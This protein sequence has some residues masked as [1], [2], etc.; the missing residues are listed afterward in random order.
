MDAI[1]SKLF[2]SQQMTVLM[3]PYMLLCLHSHTFAHT[4]GI[5]LNSNTLR[6]L[7][8]AANRWRFWKWHGSSIRWYFHMYYSITYKV[9]NNGGVDFKFKTRM[10]R[11]SRSLCRWSSRTAI[12]FA[13]VFKCS[14]DVNK[15]R[16]N[17]SKRIFETYSR[18]NFIFASIFEFFEWKYTGDVDSTVGYNIVI[19]HHKQTYF[20]HLPLALQVWMWLTSQIVILSKS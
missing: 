4:R 15:W 3:T 19:R 17:V 13:P 16:T 20:I 6:Q 8:T 5:E 12:Y 1:V 18:K 14:C 9:G 7:N 10:Y 11:V 2:L